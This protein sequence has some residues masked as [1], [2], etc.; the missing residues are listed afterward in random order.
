MVGFEVLKGRGRE[1]PRAKT[2]EISWVREEKTV[3]AA[4]LY[5]TTNP[6]LFLAGITTD[7]LMESFHVAGGVGVLIALTGNEDVSGGNYFKPG[8]GEYF[9]K[10]EE[11]YLHFLLRPREMT[12][13]DM[14]EKGASKFPGAIGRMKIRPWQ[15]SGA[16]PFAEGC[17]E[18]D[19]PDQP[20]CFRLDL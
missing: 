2:A 18:K 20:V 11:E 8:F 4:R 13:R 10:D 16:D 5:D 3:Q 19:R 7:H 9:W 6:S 14:R 12:S 1:C 15:M 17:F